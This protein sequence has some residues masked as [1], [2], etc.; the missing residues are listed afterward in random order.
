MRLLA[1]FS[2]CDSHGR[3]PER[4]AASTK[5]H[6]QFRGPVVKKKMLWNMYRVH[7][8]AETGEEEK[9]R[10]QRRLEKEKQTHEHTR[11]AGRKRKPTS[12]TTSRSAP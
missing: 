12:T 6:E 4:D 10:D 11:W 5:T 9:G 7:L 8:H 2:P 3:A 1:S